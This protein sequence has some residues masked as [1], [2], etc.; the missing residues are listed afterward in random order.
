M[1]PVTDMNNKQLIF[2]ML[3]YSIFVVLGLGLISWTIWVTDIRRYL[4][5]HGR[6]PSPIFFNFGLGPFIDYWRARDIV[7]V[8]GRKPR[9]LWIFEWVW[10]VKFL[11][12]MLDMIMLGSL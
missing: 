2:D 6:E 11:I 12:I 5:R 1:I 3:M 10:G 7:K 4:K 9:F 8:S